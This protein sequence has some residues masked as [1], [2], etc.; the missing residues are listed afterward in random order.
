MKKQILV[1]AIKQELK[2]LNELFLTFDNKNLFVEE[3]RLNI[4]ITIITY[5]KLLSKKRNRILINMINLIRIQ[6]KIKHEYIISKYNSVKTI[7]NKII[8]INNIILKN[9]NI[10]LKL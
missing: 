3:S 1:K 5:F 2:K 6:N 4:K 8:Y 10:L 9:Y 7:Y